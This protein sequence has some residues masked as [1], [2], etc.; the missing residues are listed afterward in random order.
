[1]SLFNELKRRNVFRVGIAYIVVAWLLAQVADL[2][3]ENFG[4]PDW[5][6]KTLLFILALGFPLALFFAWA[7]ELTPEG[8]KK[9]KD[10]DR[11]Q[12]ITHHTGRKLDFV[13]IGILVIALGYFAYDKFVAQPVSETE[14]TVSSSEPEGEAATADKSIAVL[15][16]VNMSSDPEQEYFSDGISEE[17]LNA[18]AKIKEL[19][20][21]GRTSS[22]SFKGK[23]EDLRLIG[24]ALSV[25]HILEGSVR[26]SGNQIRITAQLIKVDDG[27]HMWSETYDRELTDIFAIQD[28]ISAAILEQMKLQLIGDESPVQLASTRGDVEAYNLYLAAKQN[29]YKRDKASLELASSLLERAN[30]IDPEYA[31]AY[32]QRGIALLLSTAA[33]PVARI[34][35]VDQRGDAEAIATVCLTAAGAVVLR[36][37]SLG[38]PIPVS[39]MTVSLDLTTAS[40]TWRI[41]IFLPLRCVEVQDFKLM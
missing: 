9:E 17:I 4:S 7:F 26:K 40:S 29:I 39:V 27:Y 13:I 32:A 41:L 21:A 3:L 2:A 12:S 15:P 36:Y 33:F 14:L 23:N 5:V 31:P 28:E 18:L 8:I 16:F 6:I 22:F 38:I 20:V 24:K 35:L 30:T 37:R 11:S 34:V 25:A 1:M 19:K 10:V